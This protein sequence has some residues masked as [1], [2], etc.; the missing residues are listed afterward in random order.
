MDDAQVAFDENGRPF[1]I[2]RDQ[3]KQSRLRGLDAHKANILAARTVANIMRSSLGPTGMDKMLVSGDQEITVTN[4]GATILQ[5]ME[6]QHQIGKL[7]VELSQSQDSEIGDGTTGVVVLAGC[8]LEEAEKLL[9]RG[10]HPIRVA[11]GFEKSAEIACAHLETISDVV[12]W[13]PEDTSLLLQTASTTLGSKIINRFQAQ[14]AKIAVDAVLSVA[15]LH[16]KDVNFDLI[17]MEG[18]VGAR[19][20]DTM[21]VK[22]I[23]VDKPM[24]HPQMRKVVKDAKIA[25]LTCAFEPPKPKTKHKVT[26]DTAEKYQNLYEIEQKYFVD[27]VKMCK[28]SGATLVLCQWGFDDEPNHLLLAN[29]LPAVRWVGGVELELIAIAT[30]ARIVPRFE[31]LTPEKLGKAGMVREIEMGTD[32]ERML[33]IEDCPQSRAVT[34]LVRGGNTMI[35]EEAKRSLHD[36]MCV[37]RNL[38]IDNRIVYGGGSAELACGFKIMEEANKDPSVEQYAMR[39]FCQALEGIPLAL[40]ENSG[41]SPVQALSEVKAAQLRT[42]NPFLGIDCLQKGTLDMKVQRVFET[43][44]GKKQQLL[45]AT[46]LV[47]MILKIDDIMT[48][49]DYS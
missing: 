41:F 20:E 47:K 4:D 30:G 23:V 22:G 28:Q 19:L 3:G 25:L 2:L 32:A 42:N 48:P 18:K 49:T 21:L 35:V 6:V 43:L 1:I 40:A 15:D 44:I 9:V 39:G 46:Q 13:S 8:L 45:L 12:A 29:D 26:I 11:R 24:S 14:M 37:V 27:Q 7:L 33:V 34:V 17:K 31:E 10:I 38:I 36:A 16:N 5:K